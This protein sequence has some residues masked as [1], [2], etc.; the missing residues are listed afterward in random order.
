LN[1]A[2]PATDAKQFLEYLR[3]HDITYKLCP[4]GQDC[5]KEPYRPLFLSVTSAGD[6]ANQIALPIGQT[7]A[8]MQMKTRHYDKP[9]PTSIPDQSTYFTH[10]TAL[11]PALRSHEF[12]PC[13]AGAPPYPLPIKLTRTQTCY[14]FSPIQN[15]WNQTPY[16]VAS[17][18]IQIVPNHT[19]IFRKEFVDFVE[20]FLPP[21]AAPGQPKLRPTLR[22]R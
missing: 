7:A 13:A 18:P 20:A 22:M 6:T 3:C 12:K 2:A 9:D 21:L 14:D 11:I 5:S 1:E 8:S 16:W 17:M 10:T 19:D 4:D 15:A